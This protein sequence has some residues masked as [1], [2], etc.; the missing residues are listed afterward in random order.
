MAWSAAIEAEKQCGMILSVRWWLF[1]IIEGGR[2]APGAR[3]NRWDV[4]AYGST[5]PFREAAIRDLSS[6]DVHQLT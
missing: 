2:N 4:V 6:R 3:N 5:K 1:A